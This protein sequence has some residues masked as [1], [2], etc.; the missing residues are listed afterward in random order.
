ME[1]TNN[2]ISF[3]DEKGNTFEM[4][5]L[6][7]FDYKSKRYAVLMDDNCDDDCNCEEECT[8]GCNDDKE[9]NCNENNIYILEITKDKK[10]NEILKE[11]EDKK[12]L[13]AV[14]KEADRVLYEE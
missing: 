13:D 3:K 1:E 7:E 9:C 11:I 14:I 8:C 4:I 2:V 5:V 6:K 12:I 10:G